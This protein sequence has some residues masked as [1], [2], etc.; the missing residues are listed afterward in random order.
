MLP[1]HF[2]NLVMA[3]LDNIQFEFFPTLRRGNQ[4]QV[5]DK[6]VSAW[7][8]TLAKEFPEDDNP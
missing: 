1:V 4:P 2:V 8:D 7:M 5:E 3:D 6:D